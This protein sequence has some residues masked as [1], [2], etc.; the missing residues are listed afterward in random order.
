MYKRNPLIEIYVLVSRKVL[1]LEIRPMKENNA[2]LA[3]HVSHSKQILV[4]ITS[5]H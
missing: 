1:R 2:P 5:L 3:K 4:N